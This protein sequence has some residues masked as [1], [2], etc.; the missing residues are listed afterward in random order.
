MEPTQPFPALVSAENSR[1]VSP[2]SAQGSASSG[3]PLSSNKGAAKSRHGNR[4]QQNRNK[5]AKSSAGN[6]GG[7]AAAG[8]NPGAQES[9]RASTS[10]SNSRGRK[11]AVKPKPQHAKLADASSQSGGSE[12][13]RPSGR[14]QRRS[15][16]SPKNVTAPQGMQDSKSASSS[17]VSSSQQQAE[18]PQNPAMS[19]AAGRG[20]AVGTLPTPTIITGEDG[21]ARVVFDTQTENSYA[22]QPRRS[23]LDNHLGHMPARGWTGAY[24]G[25]LGLGAGMPMHAAARGGS[26]TVTTSAAENAGGSGEPPSFRNRSMTSTQLRATARPFAPQHS[27]PQRR[28]LSSAVD[29]LAVPLSAPASS[30]ARG[31]SQSASTHVSMTGL[32]ISMAQ[33]QPGN[34]MAPHLP[35]PARGHLALAGAYSNGGYFASR[36][37]SVSNVGLAVDPS[38]S[39]R[40]PTVMF[41]RQKPDV[42]QPILAADTSLPTPTSA[43][44]PDSTGSEPEPAETPGESLAMRR[45]QEM[46]ASMRAMAPPK[47]ARDHQDATPPIS[48]SAPAP[49]SAPAHLA[50]VISPTPAT[51]PSSRFD[52]ILEEDEDTEQDEAILDAEDCSAPTHA[53]DSRA[54]SAALYAL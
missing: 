8:G 30:G 39:I 14:S 53:M 19:I 48:A 27:V 38:H 45:L 47:P 3:S 2:A 26:R 24:G 9:D 21:R 42:P 44:A 46:I 41:Q 17:P 50:P 34:V 20:K 49:T 5:L 40:I 6:P 25:H 11:K 35:M 31:R 37:A 1:S 13:G 52:S 15:K 36:R 43:S 23:T 28:S 51:H 18:A 22:H 12:T 33:S 29:G 7:A 32:R 10:G 54:K 4:R 16:K